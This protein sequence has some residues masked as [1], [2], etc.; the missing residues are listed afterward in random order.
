MFYGDVIM[1]FNYMWLNNQVTALGLT[2]VALFPA[3]PLPAFQDCM[4]QPLFLVLWAK[5]A[6]GRGNTEVS[7]S[8]LRSEV[9]QKARQ[10]TSLWLHTY[11]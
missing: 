7:L 9:K 10:K 6:W 8:R 1:T 5:V 3:R 11:W 4:Q 2:T